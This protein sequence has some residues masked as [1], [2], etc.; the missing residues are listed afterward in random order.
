[1]RRAHRSPAYA[2]LALMLVALLSAVLLGGVQERACA[3]H[4]LGAARSEGVATAGMMH[5]G[6][7]SAMAH[8]GGDGSQDAD[9]PGCDCTCIGQ[10]SMGAPP[11]APPPAA[12]LPAAP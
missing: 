1:M 12:T 3:R 9:H 2:R 7:A 4:G 10:R 11:A 8:A 5:A 6:H